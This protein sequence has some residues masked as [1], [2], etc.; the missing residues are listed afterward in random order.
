M[1]FYVQGIVKGKDNPL[2]NQKGRYYL[3]RTHQLTKK[4]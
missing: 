2:E 3:W 4:H 1:K